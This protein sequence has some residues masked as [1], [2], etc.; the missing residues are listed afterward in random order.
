MIFQ[1]TLPMRGATLGL[2]VYVYHLDISIHAPHAGSDLEL[3]SII[4]SPLRFQSTLP[5][6]GATGISMIKL[7]VKGYFN[8]RS[9]C[10]ERRVRFNGH[11]S[12]RKFQSTLPMRGATKAKR[13]NG[14]FLSISIHAPHAG[15]DSLVLIL[16]KK[17]IISIHAPHAGSD[18]L[19]SSLTLPL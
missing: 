2:Q 15:S 3:L 19:F 8:P 1:S 16:V 7:N 18:A 12:T 17:S 5:M 10:G 11:T 14:R 13:R 6:R 4:F 9:P